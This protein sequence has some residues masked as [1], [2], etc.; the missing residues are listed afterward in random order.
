LF[1][2][3]VVLVLA[4]APKPCWAQTKLYMK[5]GT[6]LLVKSYQIQGD[7]V[8]Y[9]SV[10]EGQWEDMPLSLVDLKATEG[11][12]TARQEQQQQVLQE[13]RKAVRDNYQMPQNTGFQIAP[14][15]RLPFQEGLYVYDG[16]R[17]TT[18]MQSQGTLVRDKKRMALTMAVPGPLLKGRSIVILPGNA[19]A[20]RILSPDPTFYAQFADGA[21]SRL[22]LVRLKAGKDDRAVEKISAERKG[23]TSES[24]TALPLQVTKITPIL[25]KL[26]PAQS[27]APGEYALGEIEAD[28]RLN[29]A[30][31]DFGIDSLNGTTKHTRHIPG[32]GIRGLGIPSSNPGSRVPN[33]EPRNP[34]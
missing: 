33:T 1:L 32:L 34:N 6:Y 2:F 4:A 30:V 27:L 21:G 25:F 18:M 17:L 3:A 20:V 8:H 11:A 19:A 16:V 7:R 9:Y 14:D 15:V 22:V 29:L 26:K 5:D 31:W 28:N 23:Q 24:R 12:I 13:A 10:A